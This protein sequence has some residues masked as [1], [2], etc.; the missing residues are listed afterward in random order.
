MRRAP[1]A[2][3]LQERGSM[4]AKANMLKLLQEMRGFAEIAQRRPPP[5]SPVLAL[6]QMRA[7]ATHGILRRRKLSIAINTQPQ[8]DIPHQVRIVILKPAPAAVSA[9][10]P[11]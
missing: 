1:L 5:R 8:P 4:A 3:D 2:R 10:P 11:A 6:S 9:P 7:S